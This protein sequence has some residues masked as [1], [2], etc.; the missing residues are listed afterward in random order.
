MRNWVTSNRLFVL[1]TANPTILESR[2]APPEIIESNDIFFVYIH[3][4][5]AKSLT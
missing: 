5:N 1:P 3:G 2:H 4:S